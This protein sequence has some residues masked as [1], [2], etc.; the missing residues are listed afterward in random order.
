MSLQ[1]EINMNSLRKTSLML[2]IP[3]LCFS[4]T[5]FASHSWGNYHWASTTTPFTLQVIDSTSVDWDYE[6]TMTLDKWSQSNI[7]AFDIPTVDDGNRARK[8][9]SM[10]IGQ[11]RVC[12]ASYGRNGWLG[13]ASINLDSQGHIT[14]GTAKMNDSYSEYW[15]IPGERNHVMCQEVG[16][17]LGLGHTSENGSSQKTCMDYSNSVD[18]QWPNDHDYQMLD[19]IYNH[20]DTYNSYVGN[21]S[22]EPPKPCKGKKCNNKGFGLGHRIYGNEHFE[23]W[24]EPQADG[25][26]TLHHVY[27]ASGQEDHE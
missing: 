16:H 19:T 20:L 10:A 22:T 7:L 12:N 26:L 23:V 13:L 6:F 27:L 11:I 17:L 5:S 4:A 14:R 25:S 2:T 3:L 21:G 18:S 9:C 24:A 1:Q 8:R 15:S